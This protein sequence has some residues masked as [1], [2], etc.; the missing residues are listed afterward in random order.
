[1]AGFFSDM[2]ESD[3]NEAPRKET[4]P[5]VVA[6]EVDEE[7]NETMPEESGFSSDNSMEVPDDIMLDGPGMVSMADLS[8]DDYM[9]D[10]ED[11][12][13]GMPDDSEENAPLEDDSR[14]AAPIEESI[15]DASFKDDSISAAPIGEADE[16]FGELIVKN[17]TKAAPPEKKTK[18]SKK[19]PVQETP[20]KQKE[21]PKVVEKGNDVS[22]K[23]T[24]I[25]AGTVITGSIQ[26]KDNILVE[27]VV[28][29]H[30]EAKNIVIQNGGQ[31]KEGAAAEENLEIHGNIDGDI[32]G[33]NVRLCQSKIRG[34][35]TSKGRISVD[36]DSIL[37]GDVTEG[38][39]I[40]IYGRVRG[41]ISV[42]GKATIHRG[43]IV[44]GSVRCL[45]I[46][47]E[48]GARFQ[49]SVEQVVAED[50]SDDL[51]E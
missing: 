34:N 6:P 43:S 7:S 31:V 40:D 28:E 15:E 9:N 2:D 27:G 29:G 48:T 16:D 20:A 11:D 23:G 13:E 49:G 12:M 4:P 8:G 33:R 39:D 42:T 37:N 35:I 47:L 25:T 38:E 46:Y 36:K 44:K 1:M 30:V 14:R 10:P 24:I 5:I 26:S 3:F 41:M 21:E 18:S 50:I 17:T 45:D 22:V 19:E 32:S 51:F